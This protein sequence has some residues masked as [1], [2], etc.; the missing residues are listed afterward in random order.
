MDTVTAAYNAVKEKHTATQTALSSAEDLLQ[1]LLTGLAGTSAQSSGGGGGYMGQI[2]DARARLAQAAAEEEQ[3][4]V[5]LDMSRRELA[6]LE[7]RW[8][9]V[10]REAGQGERDVKKMRTE[11]EMLHKK[12]DATG[13][14]S[15]K[16]H[17]SEEALRSAKDD[18]MRCTRVRGLS[19]RRRNGS[20]NLQTCR[21][22]T[23]CARGCRSSILTIPHPRVS[24]HAKSR[25]SWHRY[26]R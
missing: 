23:R 17:A 22:A 26:S 2:A 8:K 21:N 14:S 9:A 25:A 5:R 16:E 18:A 15:E 7:K 12:V 19:S 1:T 10:E 4:R 3:L 13:W 20:L 11:V 24:T 6:E